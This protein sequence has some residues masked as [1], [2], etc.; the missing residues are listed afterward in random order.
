MRFLISGGAGYIGSTVAHYLIDRGHEVT[1]V[2][3]LLNGF[4]RNIPKKATFFKIDISDTKKL[5]NIF[6]IK[7]FDFVF[8]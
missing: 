7:K 8:L 1:I 3:N 4:R 6:L 2:D 5:N